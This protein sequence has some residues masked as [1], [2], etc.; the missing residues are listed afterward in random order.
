VDLISHIGVMPHT[1]SVREATTTQ[2]LPDQALGPEFEAMLQGFKTA[3]FSDVNSPGY[4]RAVDQGLAH[5]VTLIQTVQS[6]IW[7]KTTPLERRIAGRFLA[8]QTGAPPVD[9]GRGLRANPTV[10]ESE[11]WF[12]NQR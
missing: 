7:A 6:R 10:T 5:Y 8:I 3:Q 9:L 1:V 11:L 2:A 4:W 12:P